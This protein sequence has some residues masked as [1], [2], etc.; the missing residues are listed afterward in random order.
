M[1][2]ET[3]IS[4]RDVMKAALG[5]AFASGVTEVQTLDMDES[6]VALVFRCPHRL[7]DAVWNDIRSQFSNVLKDTP[8]ANV[9]VLILE[10]GCSLEAVRLPVKDRE[11]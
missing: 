5:T 1:S 6:T 8:L 11:A 3:G 9:P 4:R 7:S 2:N 10:D